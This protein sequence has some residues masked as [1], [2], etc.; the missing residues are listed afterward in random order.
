MAKAPQDGVS[1]ADETTERSSASV[2]QYLSNR[3]LIVCGDEDPSVR[4]WRMAAA[5]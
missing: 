4:A 1:G 2:A 3:S 5:I